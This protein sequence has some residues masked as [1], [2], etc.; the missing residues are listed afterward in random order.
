[1]PV[2]GLD[3]VGWKAA[4]MRPWTETSRSRSPRTT[5]ASRT[6]ARSIERSALN[7]RLSD[8]A[9]NATTTSTTT[10]RIPGT[11]SLFASGR[12]LPIGWSMA[13]ASWII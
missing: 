8:G 5:V 7:Q 11:I 1:M 4:T 6:F 13:E 12:L 9:M 3:V 10:R 2:A